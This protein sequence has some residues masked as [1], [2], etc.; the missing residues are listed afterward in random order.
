MGKRKGF[1]GTGPTTGTLGALMM[2]GALLVIAGCGQQTSKMEEDQIRLETMIEIHSQQM[3]AIAENIEQNQ[4]MLRAGIQDVRK[5][6]ESL[7]VGVA[8]V[9]TEQSK[10]VKMVQEN[11]RRTGERTAALEQRLETGIDDIRGGTAR[12]SSQVAAV[13]AGQAKFRQMVGEDSRKLSERAVALAQGQENLGA[14]IAAVQSSAQKAGAELAAV[15]ERQVTLEDMVAERT[16]AI[17]DEV[18]VVRQSQQGLQV[19]IAGIRKDSDKMAARVANIENGQASIQESLANS[20]GDMAAR[21]ADL[22]ENQAKLEAAIGEVK[23]RTETTAAGIA[24]V[25][26]E[27]VKLQKLVQESGRDMAG[28]VAALEKN[29]QKLENGIS[30]VS[31]VTERLAVSIAALSS[32]QVRLEELITNNTLA[33]DDKFA[34][35]GQDEQRRDQRAEALQ[36]SIGQ[37]AAAV[38]T[39]EK[40]MA[41]LQEALAKNAQNLETAAGAGSRERSQLQQKIQRDMRAMIE[42]IDALKRSQAQ[43]EKQLAEGPDNSV[44]IDSIA[45][46]IERLRSEGGQTGPVEGV[47]TN[48]ATPPAGETV[49]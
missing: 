48:E 41:G 4:Q 8:A 43:L 42:A 3:A 24:T 5:D 33:L 31:A 26:S 21:I 49:E 10:L 32:G 9:G 14:A 1:A 34:V 36:M 11:D 25:G 44:L 13:D 35:I 30:A 38:A 29:Q 19:H 47:G 46:A 23:S 12:I 17:G 18:A 20:S 22:Q 16:R 40:N 37:I 6:T 39:L 15:S 2:V 45:I 7:S 28:K 27:Q